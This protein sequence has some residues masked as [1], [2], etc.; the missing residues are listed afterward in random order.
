MFTREKLP[1]CPRRA[2]VDCRG[3]QN[4]GCDIGTAPFQD[5]S[6][7][8]WKSVLIQTDASLVF[9]SVYGSQWTAYGRV[10]L[11]MMPYFT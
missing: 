9:S 10:P 3:D 11:S 7:W 5:L 6:S 2:R 1:I 4:E 8:K